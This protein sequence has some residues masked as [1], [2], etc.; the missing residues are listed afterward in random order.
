MDRRLF[1]GLNN[2]SSTIT[3]GISAVDTS[4]TVATFSTL[5][6][7]VPGEYFYLTFSGQ[8]GNTPEIVRVTARASGVLTITRAQD[9]TTAQAWSANAL[10]EAYITDGDLEQFAQ[11]VDNTGNAKGTNALDIQSGR[12]GVTRVASGTQ[13]TALG[14]DNLASASSA[15]AVGTG[16]T[17]S[18]SNSAAFGRNN[19]A[20]GAD[21]VAIGNTATASQARSV[22]V[23]LNCTASGAGDS[24]AVGN[25]CTASGTFSGAFGDGAV[26]SGQGA[27]AIGGFAPSAAGADA[28]AVGTSA[29]AAFTNSVAVGRAAATGATQVDAVALG[30]G[31]SVTNGN[32]GVAIGKSAIGSNDSVAVGSGASTGTSTNAVSIGKSAVTTG[33]GTTVGANTTNAGTDCVIVGSS[34]SS[35]AAGTS[36]LALGS[37]ASVSANQATAIGTFAIARV[38]KMMNEAGTNIVRNHDGNWSGSSDELFAYAGRETIVFGK[39]IT[40]TAAAADDVVAITIPSG[41]RFYVDEVG[42]IIG[43]SNTVTVNPQVSFGIT[44]D[45]TALLAQTAITAVAQYNRT[46]FQTP[47]SIHGQGSLTFSVKVSA[48]ATTLVG[49]PYFKGICVEV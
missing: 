14:Y 2:Y 7:P 45:T 30:S 31:A 8:V 9:G 23:G 1:N 16:N 25:N 49:R 24:T 11:G 43:T 34:A 35:T 12:T 27:T 42:I 5:P 28:V 21:A 37:N 32:N 33:G 22:A 15:T 13:A 19:A 41:A 29:S 38:E 48:T 46:R 47:V 18:G 4:C 3:A 36:A 40:L 20:S 26:A 17:A 39:D 10:I 44:G 6:S